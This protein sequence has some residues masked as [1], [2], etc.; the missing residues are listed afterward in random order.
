MFITLNNALISGD[1]QQRK[2]ISAKGEI[3]SPPA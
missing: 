2:S 3:P 1:N